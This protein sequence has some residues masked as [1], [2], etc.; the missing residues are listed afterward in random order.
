MKIGKYFGTDKT[1]HILE[2]PLRFVNRLIMSMYP[3]KYMAEV[4]VNIV[5]VVDAYVVEKKMDIILIKMKPYN[6]PIAILISE[7]KGTVS[8]ELAVLYRHKIFITDCLKV[9][10]SD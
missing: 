6:Y 5:C 10:K 7:L 3:A 4:T 2:A 8:T 9:D 1:Y